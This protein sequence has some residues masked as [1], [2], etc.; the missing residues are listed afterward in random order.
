MIFII[1]IIFTIIIIHTDCIYRR[2]I[3]GM[4]RYDGIPSSEI[5]R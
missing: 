3:Q 4:K 1:I 5:A 2:S